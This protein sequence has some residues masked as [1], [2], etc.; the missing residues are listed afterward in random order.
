[1]NN[2]LKH[3][4]DLFKKHVE[5]FESDTSV[6]LWRKLS[7][8]LLLKKFGVWIGIGAVLSGMILTYFLL[9]P[10]ENINQSGVMI[11]NNRNTDS[12]TNF[13]NFQDKISKSIDE[14]NKRQYEIDLKILNSTDN[15]KQNPKEAETYISTKNTNSEQAQETQVQNDQVKSKIDSKFQLISTAHESENIISSIS[16]LPILNQ[17]KIA[18]EPNAIH[19]DLIIIK[20][21]S[22]H[23]STVPG[24]E[25][26]KQKS[27]FANEWSLDLFVNPSYI[28]QS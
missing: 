19:T 2:N 5:G 26:P 16:L 15:I 27:T 25:K 6:N 1:M 3:I 4:D 24:P 13:N 8:L 28:D 20:N 7:W 12:S 23:L 17:E 11:N 10:S 14:N 9:S 18:I 21:N 22:L